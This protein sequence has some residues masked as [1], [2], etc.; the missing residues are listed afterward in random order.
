MSWGRY[1]PASHLTD[2][3]IDE[4]IRAERHRWMYRDESK[5]D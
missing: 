4:W 2:E 1:A 5:I 3:Q